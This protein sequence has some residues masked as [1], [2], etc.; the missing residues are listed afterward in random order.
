MPACDG[1]MQK[2]HLIAQQVLNR[3]GL[4]ADRWRPAVWVWA[5]QKHHTAFDDACT[6]RLPRAAIPT[7]TERFASDHKLTWYLDRT[8]R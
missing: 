4:Y 7:S 5:C 8:Y 3:E 6:I 2:A 1:P